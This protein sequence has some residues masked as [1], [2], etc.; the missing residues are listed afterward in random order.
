MDIPRR[1][2]HRAMKPLWIL[3]VATPC[4]DYTVAD[5]ECGYAIKSDGGRAVFS[6]LLE[7]D[8]VHLDV[9]D[10]TQEY[11]KYGWA[12]QAFDMTKEEARGPY[13][14]LFTLDNV[15]SSTIPNAKVFDQIGNRGGDAGL[16]L[17]VG[18][19]VVNGMVTSAEMSTTDLH[20]FYGTFR[21]G[22]KLTDVP[23]TCSAFFWV[24]TPPSWSGAQTTHTPVIWHFTTQLT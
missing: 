11:G 20:F 9:T 17:S 24:R 2:L 21:A 3:A 18:S 19:K 6:D 5:C 1:P 22:M 8:F 10:R 16:H 14:E 13:G 23:G 7:S 12:A 15:V 4:F